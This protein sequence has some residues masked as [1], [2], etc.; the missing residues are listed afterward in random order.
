[1]ISI[2]SN[3]KKVFTGELFKNTVDRYELPD[4]EDVKPDY[5][6]YIM[7]AIVT[8]AVLAVLYFIIKP[9]K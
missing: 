7:A 9:K 2:F 1:M 4:G 5:G 6:P 8:L 3:I